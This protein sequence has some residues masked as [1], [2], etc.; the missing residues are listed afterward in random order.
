MMKKLHVLGLA[1]LAVFAFGAIVAA[2]A[3]ALEFDLAEWLENGLEIPAGQTRAS[4]TEGELL[5]E[6]T[7]IGIKIDA[8]CSG[9]FIGNVGADGADTIT[10]LQNLAKSTISSTPLTEPGLLCTNDENCPEPLAWADNL[11]WETLLEW[12][13]GDGEEFYADLLNNAGK[14][15]GYHLI[16]M[17]SFGLEDLCT[18]SESASR[19]TN[20]AGGVVDGEFSEPFTEL[21]GFKLANCEKAGAEKGIVEGLGFVLLT[22]G[23]ALSMNHV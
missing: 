12:V 16:C 4:D 18:S 9:I 5:L 17:G 6:E 19:M 22:S 15:V 23:A 2:S 8:L 1:L 20:E 14:N 7:V 3:S 10:S 21:M 13:L 11:P